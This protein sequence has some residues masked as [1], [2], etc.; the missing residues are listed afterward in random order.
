MV[1]LTYFLAAALI[2]TLGTQALAIGE[3]KLTFNCERSVGRIYL[4]QKNWKATGA[5]LD[6]DRSAPL[7]EARGTVVLPAQSDCLLIANYN[8]TSNIDA[9]E[10]LKADDLDCLD[11]SKLELGSDQIRQIGR[12]TGLKRLHLEGCDIDD[13]CFTTLS[14]LTNLEY[15][16][17]SKTLI[18]GRELNRLTGLRKLR[19][20]Y[21]SYTEL[22]SKAVDQ[23]S[24][25]KQLTA[26]HVNG[27]GLTDGDLAKLSRLENLTDLAL[28]GNAHIDDRAMAS[29]G[30]LKHLRWLA[31]GQ[32]AVSGAGLKRL[33][34]LKPAAISFNMHSLTANQLLDLQK[35]LPHT[36][37]EDFS[38]GRLDQTIF[39]P[40]H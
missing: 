3:R 24:N 14:S 40:L 27:C 29:L 22:D 32:T 38:Q 16:N 2:F 20:L 34:S 4:L 13:G 25:L 39:S 31:L 30:S 9:L 21:L 18:K 15:L 33:S 8:L 10:S 6:I 28:A 12:L 5:S 17:L 26:L 1:K 7:Y 23:L 36:K 35:S 19:R 37:F 11:L